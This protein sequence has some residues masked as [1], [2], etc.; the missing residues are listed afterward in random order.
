MEFMVDDKPEV[1][2]FRAETKRLLN[3]VTH[4]L[5]SDRHVFL[6][7][8]ISNASDALER[9]RFLQ[10][11]DSESHSDHATMDALEIKLEIDPDSKSLSIQVLYWFFY[12]NFR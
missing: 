6:R 11:T 2:E 4:C 5:Y 8:L 1:H 9:R 10:L 3:I 12:F 7:E